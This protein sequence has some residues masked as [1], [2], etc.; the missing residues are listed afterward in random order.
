MVTIWPPLNCVGPLLS[1]LTFV[2]AVADAMFSLHPV[3][4]VIDGRLYR[5]LSRENLR[6][7]EV[8]LVVAVVS[9]LFF[10]FTVKD[11]EDI[12]TGAGADNDDSCDAAATIGDVI[13]DDDD[14]DD[15]GVGGSIVFCWR[16][17]FWCLCLDEVSEDKN[18]KLLEVFRLSLFVGCCV[19]SIGVE[20]FIPSFVVLVPLACS[21][22]DCCCWLL[23]SELTFAILDAAAVVNIAALGGAFGVCSDDALLKRILAISRTYPRS[24]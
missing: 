22:N 3:F 23:A 17:S 7:T 20:I 15:D 12:V 10:V 13:D 1:V 5:P 11:D 16:T 14:D 24:C 4:S 9:V 2:V 19:V 21:N 18:L 8:V 6:T